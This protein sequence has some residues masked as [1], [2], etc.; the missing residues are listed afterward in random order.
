MHML[1]VRYENSTWSV[2]LEDYPGSSASVYCSVDCRWAR[3]QSI[4][5]VHMGE[6]ERLSPEEESKC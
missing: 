2:I 6:G 3:I 5:T 4:A 1:K